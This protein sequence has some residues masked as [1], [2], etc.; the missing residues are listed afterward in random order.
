MYGR[1]A[2]NPLE[3]SFRTIKFPD[4][5]IRTLLQ[6]GSVLILRKILGDGSFIHDGLRAREHRT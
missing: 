1:S 4:I 2:F 5:S 6:E 3:S